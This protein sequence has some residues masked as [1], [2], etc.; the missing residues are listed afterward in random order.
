MAFKLDKNVPLRSIT[1]LDLSDGNRKTVGYFLT[2][3]A[4]YPSFNPRMRGR[5]NGYVILGKNHPF[6]GAK[7][8]LGNYDVHGGITFANKLKDFNIDPYPELWAYADNWV[9]GFD[10]AHAGDTAENWGLDKTVDETI[11]LSQLMNKV[12]DYIEVE[13]KNITSRIF[14]YIEGVKDIIY[15]YDGVEDRLFETNGACF[16]HIETFI[17]PHK[18]K[19]LYKY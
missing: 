19:I 7:D 10:T 8:I 18:I 11:K 6:D 15:F 16:T 9:V 17:T 14:F 3:L 4:K 5:Y 2:D 12:E 13:L 1:L